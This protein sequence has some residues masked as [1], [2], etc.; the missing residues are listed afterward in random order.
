MRSLGGLRR[1]L[2]GAIVTAIGAL[3]LVLLL[4]EDPL[5]QF[6]LRQVASETLQSALDRFAEGIA[7]REEPDALAERVGA[8]LGVRLTA[9]R[10]GRVVA[11]TGFDGE[12]L[13]RAM[14]LVEEEPFAEGRTEGPFPDEDG[15]H[16]QAFREIDDLEVHARLSAEMT[17]RARASVRELLILGSVMAVVIALFLTLVLSRTLIAPAGELTRVADALAAGDLTARYGDDDRDDE[18]GA[19][20]RALDHMAAELGERVQRLRL[21]QDRLRTILDAMIEAV[22]VTDALGRITLTNR[23]LDELS[24]KDAIGLTAREVVESE[25]LHAA[26]RAARKADARGVDLVVEREGV[27]RYFRAQVAPLPGGSGV[28]AVLHDVTRLEAAD[29]IRRDFVANASH[30]LRTPLTAIRGFAETLR[31]GAMSDPDSAERFLSIILKHTLRLQAVVA[32]LAAL[33]R[34]ESPDHRLDVEPIDLEDAV[35][36]VVGGLTTKAAQRGVTLEIEPNEQKLFAIGSERGLDQ[37]LVNLVDNAIKYTPEGTTVRIRVRQ[38]GERIRIEVHNPGRGIPAEHQERVFERFYRMDEG[39]SRDVGGTGLGLAIVKHLM[40]K[41]GGEV[42]VES[43]PDR[44]VT[45]WVGLPSTE[46]GLTAEA[47]TV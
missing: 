26:V 14:E 27:R 22:F 38:D 15:S 36:D 16:H 19:I 39:R 31:D 30:E 29:R 10:D 41:M 8:E 23:A 35:A 43:R 3:V 46:T 1:N 44:G 42:G 6:R 20:G 33:S 28:V 25:E 11:D 21:E 12:E 47:D 24:G 9:I 2:I 34:A 37:V 32:D 4:L 13:Q 45:F 7:R 5:V 17:R 40:M 18:L